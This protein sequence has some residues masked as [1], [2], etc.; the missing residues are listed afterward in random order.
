MTIT[1]RLAMANEGV[2]DLVGD[3]EYP[4]AKLV[5]GEESAARLA[6][7]SEP[8]PVQT[9]ETDSAY[10]DAFGR[11]R[12][13]LTGQRYDCEFI[14][15]KQPDLIDEVTAGGGTATHNANPRDVTLAV[16][17]ADSGTEAALYSHYDI[18]YTAGNSQNPELTGTLND[19][20]I[21][22]GKA[23]LFLRTSIS[24]TVDE[25]VIDQDKWANPVADV[26]WT[27]SQILSVDFQSLKVGRARWML[28]RSGLPVILEKIV[29]DNMRDSGYW[30]SPTLPLYWRIYNDAT[31]TYSEMGYGDTANGIGI[32]YRLPVNA[33]A[34]MRAICG[35]V[36]SEGGAET[37]DLP[38]FSRSADN[39]LTP[40]TVAATLVPILS[41]RPA[42]LFNGLPN[43]QLFVPT[44]YSVVSDN[45]IYYRL[46]YRPTLTDAS[47]AAVDAVNSGMEYDVA[48]TAVTGGIVIESDYLA[49]GRNT[50]AQAAGLLG[51]TLL[52]LGRTGTA[53]IL[54]LAGI[55]TTT[56]SASVYGVHK[57]KEIR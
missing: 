18:P 34:T 38:G 20:D 15:N 4:L 7:V 50:L 25:T 28:V 32:R 12:V 57:W 16:N 9:V 5:W 42:A 47:W 2:A 37:F 17:D 1:R 54:T 19:A 26:D 27:T 55:R 21:A 35:T 23:Q 31:Y 3:L 29:N 49:S 48:A 51:R 24:G 40:R 11:K 33:S 46:L 53:D 30:Q 43:R 45:P 6:S 52:S 10:L 56:S 8:V 39:Y 41:I 14:Y 44:S 36:K 13:S 22:G